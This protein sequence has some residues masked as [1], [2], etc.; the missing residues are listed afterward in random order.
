MLQNNST[1]RVLQAFFDEPL[2]KFYLRQLS[3][4]IS[5]SQ[6]AVMNHLHHLV[7]ERLIVRDNDALYPTYRANREEKKFCILKMHNLLLR[8]EETNVLQTIYDIALPDA[9]VLFGSCVLGEDVEESDIDLFIL[10]PEKKLHLKKYEKLLKR[11]ISLFFC[12][13]FGKLSE[14]LKNNIVN[15]IVLRGYLRIYDTNNTK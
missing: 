14:E 8:L 7:Q 6:P 9:I 4:E 3:R 1:Y 15:G 5:L 11:K 13:D 12:K 10:A 2:R